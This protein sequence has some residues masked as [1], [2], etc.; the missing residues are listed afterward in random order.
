MHMHSLVAVYIDM[1]VA[2]D[3]IPNSTHKQ[4]NLS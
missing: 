2:L 3:L 1:P 4:V